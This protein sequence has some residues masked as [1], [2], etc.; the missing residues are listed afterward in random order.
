MKIEKHGR[1]FHK[2]QKHF[3]LFVLSVDGLLGKEAQVVLSTL[4]QLV[5]AKTEE[6]ILHVKGWVNGRVTNVLAG[7]Y[8]KMLGGSRVPINLLTREP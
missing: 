2:Q 3:S 6:P 7:S 4:S 1:H 8:Y 5:A